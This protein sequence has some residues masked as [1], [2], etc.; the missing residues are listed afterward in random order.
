M[1]AIILALAPLT[2]AVPV[3]N[4]RAAPPDEQIRAAIQNLDHPQYRV[5]SGAAKQLL[6]AGAAAVEPLAEVA[7]GGSVEAADR[8]LRILREFALDGG[9]DSNRCA[10]EA[11]GRLAKS[12][13]AVSAGAREIL[14]HCRGRALDRMQA[15]G[16][17]FQFDGARARAVYLNRVDDLKAVLP[18]LREFPELE[19]VSLE[20]KK[21]GDDEM[22]Q[23]LS[24][25]N[26][27]W[28]NLFQ[29]NIGDEGLKHL[30]NFPKL[31]S[32]PMGRTRVTDAGLKHLAGLTQLE[33]VGLRGNAVTDAGL[34]HLKNLVNLTGVTLEET[35]VTGEGFANLQGMRKLTHLRLQTSEVTDRALTKLYGMKSLRIVELKGTKVTAAGIAKLREAIPDLQVDTE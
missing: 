17:S 30:K 1:Q 27:K 23:L 24:L 25:R 5:R 32:I 11:L 31:E 21:F 35:K 19:E 12:K 20:N 34:V 18:L 13:A 16:A 8:A 4:P 2:F 14:D 29:S 33:Y 3:A 26:L 6:D 28:L 10:R 22:A 9:E 7:K 15:A